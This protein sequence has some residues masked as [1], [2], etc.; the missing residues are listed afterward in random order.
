MPCATTW[1]DLEDGVL[2]EIIQTEKDKYHMISFTW[3]IQKQEKKPHY[4]RL[5]DTEN[6]SLVTRDVAT[7][8]AKSNG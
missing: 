5:T 3:G 6:R 1:I 2:S 4:T 7:G 8:W